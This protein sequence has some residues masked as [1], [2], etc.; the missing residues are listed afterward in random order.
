MLWTLTCLLGTASVAVIGF[1]VWGS[2]DV[3][4]TSAAAESKTPVSRSLAP[5]LPT[6]GEFSKITKLNLRR[7]LFDAPPPVAVVRE[8]PPPPPLTI[9]LTGTII[10]PGYNRAMLQTSEGKLKLFGEGDTCEQARIVKIEESSITVMYHGQSIVLR[11]ERT[12]GRS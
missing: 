10:E 5:S 4:A 6:L 1:G 3:L 7:P 9:K 8:A 12:S 2:Y 11:V